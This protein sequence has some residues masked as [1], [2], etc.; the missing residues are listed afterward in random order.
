MKLTQMT[1]TDF[2]NEIDSKSPTPGGGSVSALAAAMGAALAR[3]VGHLT[4]GRK[5]F[6]ALGEATQSE[7]TT[8]FNEIALIKDRLLAAV[9][10]DTAAYNGVMEAFRLPKETETEQNLRSAAIQEATVKA[11][12]VPLAVAKESFGLLEKLGPLILHGNPNTLSDV[13][14]GVMMLA[15][16]IE[17]AALNVKINLA[18]LSNKQNARDYQHEVEVLLAKTILLR[19]TVLRDI[20]QQ[21]RIE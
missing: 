5:R 1:L 9:D 20:H 18:G 7:F 14:V 11:I 8:L 2:V 12:E 21:L 13:G 15:G 19:D 16:A 10:L 17:G 4:I 6:L 3:M